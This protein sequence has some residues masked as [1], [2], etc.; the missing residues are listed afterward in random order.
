MGATGDYVISTSMAPVSTYTLFAPCFSLIQ[1][2][3]EHVPQIKAYLPTALFRLVLTASALFTNL[4]LLP[5]EMT[6][7]DSLGCSLYGKDICPLPSVH[8][9]P[10]W[11]NG[12]VTKGAQGLGCSE[13]L[14]RHGFY[15]CKKY[16]KVLLVYFLHGDRNHC[17]KHYE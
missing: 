11:R 10:I 17:T 15:T 4:N 3:P 14:I 16:I 6:Q 7:K 5:V 2:F 12:Q 1:I 9:W 8:S 13:P